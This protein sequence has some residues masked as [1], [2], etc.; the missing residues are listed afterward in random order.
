MITVDSLVLAADLKIEYLAGSSGGGRPV[1][2][3]HAVDLPDPWEWVGA[4]DLVMTTGAGMPRTGPEQAAWLGL[5]IEAGASGLIVASP[6]D[7]IEVSDAMKETADSNGFPVLRAPFE[8]EFVSLARI[9]ITNSLMLERQQ[10]DRA[11]RLF[12]AYGESISRRSDID[13]RLGAIAR[14]VGWQLELIDDADGQPTFS[15]QFK[16][17]SL[18]QS[19]VLT[20]PGKL[21]T[22]LRIQKPFNA[23]QDA[24]LTYY[25]GAIVALELEQ[26]VRILEE[27][28]EAG[29]A[30]LRDLLEGE[31]DLSSISAF[32]QKRGFP[33][34]KVLLCIDP[35]KRGLYSAES[36]HLCRKFRE[37]PAPVL[38]QNGLLMTLVPDSHE[39]AA[40]LQKLLGNGTRIGVSMPL[41][42]AVNAPEAARQAHIA[43][44]NAR[45]SGADISVYGTD[46]DEASIFPRTLP[47]SHAIVDQ[48]L[49]KLLEHDRVAR[50]ELLRTLEVYLQ[51]DRSFVRASKQ[52]NIHRQTLVY[53]LN[54]VEQITGLH[55]S[56]TKGTTHFWFALETARRARIIST[57]ESA[58]G[59]PT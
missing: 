39:F 45:E 4:G 55:P 17:G 30:I 31:I 5:L 42:T 19:D 21:R 22:T 43:M 44:E 8:L 50:G 15:S 52:L 59:Q 51:E 18:A 12:D 10:L 27:A 34:K 25:V 24:L 53:R 36:I 7:G 23:P 28:R 38:E 54:A 32:L 35:G 26:E 40:T 29:T 56:S 2:W 33:E 49:G 47:E 57:C 20:V 3:A 48:I 14:S 46:A 16:V 1:S 41:S 9:V 37:V 13:E 11:K 6:G 58:S